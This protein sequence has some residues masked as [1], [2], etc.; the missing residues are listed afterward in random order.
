MEQL[1]QRPAGETGRPLDLPDEK[2]HECKSALV[3][4]RDEVTAVN[5]TRR[6]TGDLSLDDLEAAQA[7]EGLRAGT[8]PS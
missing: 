2:E 7:L 5:Q 1:V 3:E 6:A 4:R 8:E